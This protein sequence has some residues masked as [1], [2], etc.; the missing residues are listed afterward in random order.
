[1][2]TV[3]PVCSQLSQLL[4]H[5][6]WSVKLITELLLL[7][8][9]E[10]KEICNHFWAEIRLHTKSL[11]ILELSDFKFN[12][13]KIHLIFLRREFCKNYLKENIFANYLQCPC[14]GRTVNSGSGSGASFLW[15]IIYSILP[16][17]SVFVVLAPSPNTKWHLE[18]GV[19]PGYNSGRTK[20]S[21]HHTWTGLTFI[22]IQMRSQDLVLQCSV[23]YWAPWS[24]SWKLLVFLIIR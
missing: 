5:L 16:K 10:R 24:Y 12:S 15:A 18:V 6:P 21:F 2:K 3:F 14:L 8:I 13:F 4:L 11:S 22:V 23:N 20:A 17:S 19:T 9:G 7:V 1:M